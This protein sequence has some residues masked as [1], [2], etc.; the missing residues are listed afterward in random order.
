MTKLSI[1]IVALALGLSAV[2][3][4]R[5][6]QAANRT[7]TSTVHIDTSYTTR[8]P[9]LAPIHLAAGGYSE[10]QKVVDWNFFSNP[11][12]FDRTVSVPVPEDGIVTDAT[13]YTYWFWFVFGCAAALC[14]IAGLVVIIMR[15]ARQP[16]GACDI[17]NHYYGPQRQQGFVNVPAFTSTQ[18]IDIASNIKANQRSGRFV[19]RNGDEQIVIDLDAPADGTPAPQVPPAPVPPKS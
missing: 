15:L 17:H 14:F 10:Y 8:E 5:P 1:I 16:Y 9:V 19:Y 2:T 6:T 3:S 12:H 11:M 4:C 7:V 13:Y 18:L